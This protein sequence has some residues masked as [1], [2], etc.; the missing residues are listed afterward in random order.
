MKK[1]ILIVIFFS[2]LSCF[3]SCDD[4]L[5]NSSANKETKDSAYIVIE[6]TMFEICNK[7]LLLFFDKELEK[8]KIDYEVCKGIIFNEYKDIQIGEDPKLIYYSGHV[9]LNSRDEGIMDFFIKYNKET[10][11][12]VALGYNSRMENFHNISL[13]K[14]DAIDI[15]KKFIDSKGITNSDLLELIDFRTESGNTRIT[16]K[17]QD[18]SGKIHLGIEDAYKEVRMFII[19]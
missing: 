9:K 1:N 13:V 8:S 4:K 17:M 18:T 5:L 6:D 10:E 11:S 14:A 3:V 15:S 12:V 7:N 2:I 19:E 16:F